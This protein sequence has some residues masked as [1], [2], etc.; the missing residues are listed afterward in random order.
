MRNCYQTFDSSLFNTAW[1]GLGHYKLDRFW[2]G[3]SS[4]SSV[5]RNMFV[6]IKRHPNSECVCRDGAREEVD[7]GARG[8]GEYF[9]VQ[10]GEC[11]LSF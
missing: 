4:K 1:L 8:R 5:G 9:G 11:T 7:V 2:S 6:C 3:G 10:C